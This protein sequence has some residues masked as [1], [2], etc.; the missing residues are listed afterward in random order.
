MAFNPNAVFISPSTLGDFEK[1]PQLYYLRSV[2]KSS[3]T[4][5]KLQLINPALAL[6]QSVHD[7]IEQFGKLDPKERAKEKL[8]QIYEIVWST[9][10]GEKGGFT[11]QDEEKEYKDRGWLMLDRFF[12][13]PHFV[14][15]TQIK[16]PD[17]PKAELGDDIILTGK[18]DWIESLGDGFHIIDFKT[19]K[20]EE[21]EDSL[22]LPIYALLAGH[23][24]K[25]S[26]VKTS[27]WYLDKEDDLRDYTLPD[28]EEFVKTLKQ[29]GTIIK[30]ARQTNSFR[31]PKGE[32]CWACKDMLAI[33]NGKGKLVAIDAAR[34]Q[35]IY[36][37]PKNEVSGVPS[38]LPF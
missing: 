16:T 19:G 5:L 22:Q 30:L 28:M 24:F 23:I 34:K 20:N 15:T 26:D 10:S 2:Y 25:S 3:Q 36:I 13:H 7:T 17:F 4:G 35:E 11:N 14:A 27:Y 37:L 31:C 9:I 6:G 1:C 18:L 12:K 8:E 32:S 21:K 33:K 29:K 38:D